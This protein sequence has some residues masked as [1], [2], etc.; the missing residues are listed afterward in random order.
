MT[1]TPSYRNHTRAPS[2][3]SYTRTNPDPEV[4]ECGCG[5][6]GR[7]F[8]RII[9]NRRRVWAEGCPIRA[10]FKTQLSKKQCA[11][12]DERRKARTAAIKERD[13]EARRLREKTKE[14]EKGKPIEDR[15]TQ[16]GTFCGLCCDLPW[17]RQFPRCPK[18]NA[19]F[20][21]EPSITPYP[22][23]MSNICRRD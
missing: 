6:C 19:M 10:A 4:R 8:Q 15:T 20:E 7:T 11:A 17:R 1:Q 5:V 21:N 14:I 23:G 13:S 12:R 9:S 22:K 18:C 16:T 3:R 2:Y